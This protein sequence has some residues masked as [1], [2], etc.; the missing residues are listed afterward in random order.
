MPG[1]LELDVRAIASGEDVGVRWSR[2]GQQLTRPRHGDGM[3]PARATLGGNQ[4]VAAVAPHKCGAS[5]N[6]IAVP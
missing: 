5:V 6:P 4:I 3:A 1:A 2:M